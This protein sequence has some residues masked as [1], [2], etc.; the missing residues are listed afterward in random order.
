MTWR[1]WWYERHGERSHL[2]VRVWQ[3]TD[4][5]TLTL[6]WCAAP[7]GDTP[8]T[9]DDAETALARLRARLVERDYVIVREDCAPWEE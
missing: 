5:V 1:L 2:D 4:P 9:A 6:R 8:V 3:E 7:Q